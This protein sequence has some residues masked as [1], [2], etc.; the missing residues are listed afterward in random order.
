MNQKYTESEKSNVTNRY[1]SGETVAELVLSTGIPRST[2]YAWIKKTNDG[3]SIKNAISIKNYRNLENKVERLQGIIEIMKKCGCTVNDPLEIKLPALEA[4]HGQYSVHMLCEALDVPRGT[5]YNYIYRNKRTHTWY[6]KRREELRIE[7]QRIFDESHQ[8]FGAEKICSVMKE[9]GIRA[10]KAMVSELM[11]D[12]GLLSI[13]QGAKDYYDKEQRRFK[14]YLNQQFTT[15]RPNE[16]WVS[17]VTCFR[18]N[19]KN[20]YICMILDLFSRMVVGYHI[21]KANSTQL[22]RSTFQ[23]AYK[24]RC[25][26]EPLTFHTDRGSNYQSKTF[27]AL[28]LSLGITQSFSRAHIPYDNSVME[29]FFSNLKREELYRTKYRSEKEFRTAVDKYVVFYNEQRPHAKNKYKTPLRKELDFWDKQ[30]AF[31]A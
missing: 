31:D 9:S 4:L 2:I 3:N 20:Y 13:R 12:M 26:T 1:N 11:H 29:T 14:N 30:A 21:G 28:L 6:A 7:I 18:F 27:R 25:P 8:I 24:E 15:T 22:V 23:M 19:N 17:D 16:V 5:Y 10:S